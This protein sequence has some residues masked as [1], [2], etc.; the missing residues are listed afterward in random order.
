M[1]GCRYTQIGKIVNSYNALKQLSKHFIVMF[2]L[3]KKNFC[4]L[5]W[6]TQR[7]AQL[8]RSLTVNSLS[9]FVKNIY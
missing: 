5:R 8:L 3:Y 2:V 4:E 6:Y 7:W 9:Y 1:K